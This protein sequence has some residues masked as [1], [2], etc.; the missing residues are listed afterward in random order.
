MSTD[1]QGQAEASLEASALQAQRRD[2]RPRGQVLGDDAE[3]GSKRSRRSGP[4][5]QLPGHGLLRSGQQSQQ[6]SIAAQ[7]TYQAAGQSSQKAGSRVPSANAASHAASHVTNGRGHSSGGLGRVEG[8]PLFSNGNY[9]YPINPN[10]LQQ[11]PPQLTLQSRKSAKKPGLPVNTDQLKTE[12]QLRLA[13]DHINR[14]GATHAAKQA[15]VASLL[16]RIRT[17]PRVNGS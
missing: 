15:A 11:P 7:H 3:K 14:S 12:A 8:P 2:K 17:L 6:G 16:Q 9:Y 10:L 13:V 5:A 4:N 1:D